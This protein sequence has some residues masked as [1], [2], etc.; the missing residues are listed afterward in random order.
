MGE[1]RICL[2]CEYPCPGFCRLAVCRIVVSSSK[3]AQRCYETTVVFPDLR[4]AQKCLVR[5]LAR[6]LS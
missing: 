6:F 3:V 4:A 2:I 1:L 5:E